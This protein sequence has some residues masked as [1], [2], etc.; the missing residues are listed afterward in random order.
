MPKTILIVDDEEAYAAFVAAL[1]RQ[2]SFVTHYV[3]SANAALNLLRTVRFDLVVTNMYMPGRDGFEL[4]QVL[5]QLHPHQH[6]IAMI[7]D[8]GELTPVFERLF[9]L[10]GGVAVI[11]KSDCETELLATLQTLPDAQP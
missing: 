5:R 1:L 10:M 2:H 11:R 7:G 4:L 6:V 9:Q 8:S 3:T